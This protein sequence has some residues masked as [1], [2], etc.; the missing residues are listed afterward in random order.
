MRRPIETIEVQEVRRYEPAEEPASGR[1]G[2][3]RVDAKER[4]LRD[5]EPG[6]ADELRDELAEG[7]VVADQDGAPRVVGGCQDRFH[8]VQVR[9]SARR[10][11]TRISR[12]SRFARGS[13]V[14]TARTFGLLMIASGRKPRRSRNRARPVGLLLTASRQGTVGVVSTPGDG[15]TGVSVAQEVELDRA[16]PRRGVRIA[17]S[18]S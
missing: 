6:G 9:P 10:R 13:A 12:P 18:L 14:W 4:S 2:P 16:M 8:L 7:G 3:L 15:I 1:G 5:I 11:S 17:L